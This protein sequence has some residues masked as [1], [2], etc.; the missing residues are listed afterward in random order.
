MVTL[1]ADYGYFENRLWLPWKLIK[2]LS[3]HIHGD[4]LIDE[5]EISWQVTQ[6]SFHSSSH[7]EDHRRWFLMYHHQIYY[8]ELVSPHRH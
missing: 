1:R 6:V 5:N 4:N 3:K 2:F 8:G 7:L